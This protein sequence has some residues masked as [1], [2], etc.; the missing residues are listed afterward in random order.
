MEQINTI[1]TD[2]VYDNLFAD[3]LDVVG[4]DEIAN[5]CI[6]IVSSVLTS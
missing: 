1:Q 5:C 3:Y 6:R 4:A 2:L